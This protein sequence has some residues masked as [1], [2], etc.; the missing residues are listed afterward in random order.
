MNVLGCVWKSRIA[1]VISALEAQQVFEELLQMLHSSNKDKF[2]HIDYDEL[3]EAEFWSSASR[4][5]PQDCSAERDVS[6][7]ARYSTKLPSKYAMRPNLMVYMNFVRDSLLKYC[8]MLQ[9]EIIAKPIER[10]REEN[11]TLIGQFSTDGDEPTI[12]D[13][14]LLCPILSLAK[15]CSMK[16]CNFA[17]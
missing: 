8:Y 12:L 11:R 6:I 10:I 14:R 16:S 17:Q 3:E 1:S 4:F 13:C 5:S 15:V 7:S 2:E 9:D